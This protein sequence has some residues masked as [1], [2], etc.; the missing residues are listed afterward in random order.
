MS[1]MFAV[2][3]VNFKYNQDWIDR[4][5]N[6]I[7]HPKAQE[8]AIIDLLKAWK[9]YADI[10]EKLYPDNNKICNDGFIGQHFEC[11]AMDLRAMLNMD[12]GRLD[13]GTLDKFILDIL[14]ENNC[15]ISKI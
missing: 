2:K 15:D 3:K 10:F 4:H 13:C 1:N 11:M 12:C 7:L 9:Q 6:A 8:K 5:N 14:Q